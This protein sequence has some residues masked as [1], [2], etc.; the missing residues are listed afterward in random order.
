MHSVTKYLNG[1]SDMVGGVLILMLFGMRIIFN[2][3]I[4]DYMPVPA[5]SK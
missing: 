2:F 5:R 3:D 4:Y 1:H